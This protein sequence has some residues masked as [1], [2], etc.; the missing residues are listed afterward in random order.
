MVVSLV[1]LMPIRKGG[2][3]RHKDRLRRGSPGSRLILEV[4]VSGKEEWGQ[5]GVVDTLDISRRFTLL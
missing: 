2:K 3:N 1:E 4:K 5:H